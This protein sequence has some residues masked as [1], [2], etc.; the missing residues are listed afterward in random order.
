[1]Y[2]DIRPATGLRDEPE[3]LLGVEPLNC[4]GCHGGIPLSCKRYLQRGTASEGHAMPP[5]LRATRRR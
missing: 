4:S 3:A 5:D 2:E 1:M